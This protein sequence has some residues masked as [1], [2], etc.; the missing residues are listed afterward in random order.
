MS[1]NAAPNDARLNFRLPSQLKQ[2]IEE[3]AARSG[4]SVSDFAVSTLV[5]TA[6]DV[7][8]QENVT[9]LSNR[10]RDVFISLLDDKEVGPNDALTAAAR[11]YQN[12]RG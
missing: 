4:Q 11:K 1:T 9:R 2:T 8:E 10:D 7:I 12:S 6:R 3:A 5:R